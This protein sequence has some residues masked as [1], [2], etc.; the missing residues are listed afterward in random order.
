MFSRSAECA[1]SSLE[2]RTT[3]TSGVAAPPPSRLFLLAGVPPPRIPSA[4]AAPVGAKAAEDDP[5]SLPTGSGVRA[6]LLVE[7]EAVAADAFLRSAPKAL[8]G[9]GGH[10][11]ACDALEYLTVPSRDCDDILDAATGPTPVAAAEPIAPDS[12]PLTLDADANCSSLLASDV[13]AEDGRTP[14]RAPLTPSPI[15]SRITPAEPTRCTAVW[16]PTL[17]ARGTDRAA[18]ACSAAAERRWTGV[19]P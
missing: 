11:L 3:V 12:P 16:C 5:S 18:L 10:I 13:P 6:A 4:D 17:P 14:G 1:F 19:V 9:C 2:R 8:G 7:T 15:G